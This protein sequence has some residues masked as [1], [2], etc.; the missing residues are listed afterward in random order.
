MEEWRDLVPIADRLGQRGAKWHGPQRIA[1][2]ARVVEL[3][4]EVAA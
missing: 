3:V 4:E 1:L 2:A